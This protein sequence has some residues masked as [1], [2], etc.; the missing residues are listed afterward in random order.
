MA[1]KK[2]KIAKGNEDISVAD[3]TAAAVT[4]PPASDPDLFPY[5]RFTSVTGVHT[6]L[7]AFTALFLPRTSLSL[8]FLTGQPEPVDVDHLGASDRALRLLT[9]NPLRTVAWLCAGVMV[10]QAWWAGWLKSWVH[11]E[12]A[13]IKEKKDAVEEKLQAKE[14]CTPW[15]APF[16]N[17]A[18]TMLVASVAFHVV[19]VLFGAPIASH[20]FE[21]Y[22]LSLL[23]ALLTTFTPAYVLGPPSLAATS[24][25]LVVRLAWIRLFAELSPRNLIERAMVYPATGALLGCWAGAIPIGLD[26]E[27]PWQAWPLTPAYGALL[28]YIVGS[29]GTLAVTAVKELARADISLARIAA[30]KA[31]AEEKKAKAKKRK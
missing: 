26:W 7:L 10:L 27:R 2:V 20:P 9:E 19:L 25:A 28:G 29:L 22:T 14:R 16:T 8:S 13:G 6:S 24:E 18:A 12:A 1:I 15:I 21:T 31:A 30:A 4:P 23:L 5:A 17:A 3:G 11:E